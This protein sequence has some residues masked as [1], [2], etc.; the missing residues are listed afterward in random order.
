LSYVPSKEKVCPHGTALR[1][2]C[3]QCAFDHVKK[4]Q[5]GV[6]SHWIPK[7]QYCYACTRTK[8]RK[9]PFTERPYIP[10]NEQRPQST[11]GQSQNFFQQQLKGNPSSNPNDPYSHQMNPSY[12]G[13]TNADQPKGAFP[14]PVNSV[15]GGRFHPT[16]DPRRS[17]RT[18]R[19]STHR[20]QY[21]QRT[22]ESDMGV[23][24]D[25]SIDDS[26]FLAEQNKG[27]L[28]GNPL[29]KR[30]FPSPMDTKMVPTP[31]DSHGGVSSRASRKVDSA[32]RNEDMFLRRSMVQPDMRH[33]NRFYEIMPDTD[34]RA[35]YRQSDNV[36]STQFQQQSAQMH[37]NHDFRQAYASGASVGRGGYSAPP[38]PSDKTQGTF[39]PKK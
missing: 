11:F 5:Q 6:C 12:E 4:S 2:D 10:V 16:T 29:I 22:G 21:T 35:S 19:E 24:M 3:Y 25:R 15:G 31:T 26:K 28:W 30:N 17:M 1:F 18:G 8:D 38:L 33:G 20:S 36:R 32:G 13:Y 39:W 9:N 27:Q 34:R 37:S 7:G 23:F 14:K